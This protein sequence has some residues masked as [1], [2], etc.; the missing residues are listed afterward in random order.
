MA[1]PLTDGTVAET[2]PYRDTG[3]MLRITVG[4]REVWQTT[5]CQVRPGDVLQVAPDS[6]IWR[7]GQDITFLAEPVALTGELQP[8]GR[9]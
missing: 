5:M 1:G 7:D 2:F 8:R 6:T 3:R 9:P 4:D